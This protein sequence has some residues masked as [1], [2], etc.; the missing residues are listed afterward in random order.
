MRRALPPGAGIDPDETARAFWLMRLEDSFG[1]ARGIRARS[2]RPRVRLEGGERLEAALQRGRGAILWGLRF[3]SAT[4][5]KQALHQAGRPL[6]HLSRAQHGSPTDTWLGLAVAAPLYCRAE[7]PYLRERVV[8][9]LG[10]STRYL[11][12]LR[13][14]L[15]ENACISIFAEHTGRRNVTRR[16]LTAELDFAVGAPSLAWSEG[17]ALLT[18]SAHREGPYQYRVAIGEEIP[19]DVSMPR[20]Q[21]AEQAVTELA[22]R[23]EQLIVQHPS[24]WQGWPYRQ[25]P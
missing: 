10:G 1:R 3:G 18:V 13:E 15:G 23:L 25:F 11:Q 12:T 9:P 8:I 2:W 4:A 24:D 20:K 17:A 19:V 21:Y 22:R 16:V 6:V 14:R 7:A 5:I